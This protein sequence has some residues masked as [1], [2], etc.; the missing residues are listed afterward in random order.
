MKASAALVQREFLEPAMD[1][2][3]LNLSQH[4]RIDNGTPDCDS[5][6]D[7]LACIDPDSR[8]ERTHLQQLRA[9]TLVLVAENMS[10]GAIERH[11]CGA[12]DVL[13]R[14]LRGVELNGVS[15]VLKA[16]G[17]ARRLRGPLSVLGTEAQL[18]S[19]ALVDAVRQVDEVLA[20]V[21]QGQLFA[22][23]VEHELGGKR[24]RLLRELHARRAG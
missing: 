15:G 13:A 4:F 3:S 16:K 18:P 20:L 1:A 10:E 14:D 11:I 8:T 5:V 2:R 6:L 12:A 23:G 19:M 22:P 17:V 21:P 9:L 7:H 24:F